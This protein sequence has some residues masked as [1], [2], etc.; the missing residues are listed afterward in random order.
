MMAPVSAMGGSP[1]FSSTSV[2]LAAFSVMMLAYY[3]L[4]GV[5]AKARG[6]LYLAASLGVVL[7]IRFTGGGDR[8]WQVF[9]LS[10]GFVLYAI[11][12]IDRVWRESRALERIITS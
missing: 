12:R 5:R 11:D 1:A 7:L 2:F 10:V 4:L 3:L 9:L 8:A 6:A